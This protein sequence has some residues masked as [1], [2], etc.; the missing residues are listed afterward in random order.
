MIFL[1][2]SHRKI[3]SES[4]FFPGG[5][6]WDAG[7]FGLKNRSKQHPS[8]R[9]PR[10]FWTFGDFQGPKC[11]SKHIFFKFYVIMTL[12]H[13]HLKIIF[14]KKKLQKLIFM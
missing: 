9:V 5:K 2:I 12:L 10:S 6:D 7:F 4:H 3:P 14:I 11:T 1:Y 13:I 8:D